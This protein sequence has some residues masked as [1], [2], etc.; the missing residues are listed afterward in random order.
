MSRRGIWCLLVVACMG[1]GSP[2]VELPALADVQAPSRYPS[3]GLECADVTNA[4]DSLSSCRII[5]RQMGC[6]GNIEF[7]VDVDALGQNAAINWSGSTAPEL[8]SC[9]GRAVRDAALGPPTDAQGRFRRS[10]TTG[11]VSW[12][13]GDVG[14]S[15]SLANVAGTIP[16]L[17]PSC[18][19]K[20]SHSQ[21]VVSLFSGRPNNGL[22]LTKRGG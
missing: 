12:D 16:A 13:F 9:I 6:T 18:I 21:P 5:A 15:H 3:M 14:Y 22:K 20:A 1:C 8:R 7:E 11:A 19:T 2:T 4:G 10:S 17:D